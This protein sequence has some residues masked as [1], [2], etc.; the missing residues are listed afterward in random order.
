MTITDVMAKV[1]ELA[2]D[3]TMCL[4]AELEKLKPLV[5]RWEGRG[6]RKVQCQDPNCAQIWAD[7]RVLIPNETHC[8][9]CGVP[10]NNW[11]LYQVD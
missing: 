9:K 2:K 1:P 5:D 11:D 3:I 10:K 4:L 6:F 7:A 8:P